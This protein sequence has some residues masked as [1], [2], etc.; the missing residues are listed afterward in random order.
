[1]RHFCYRSNKTDLEKQA[2]VKRS[3]MLT[4]RT[5]NSILYFTNT[6]LATKR[7]NVIWESNILVFCTALL[8]GKHFVKIRSLSSYAPY[9]QKPQ[10]MP[11]NQ[12]EKSCTNPEAETPDFRLSFCKSCRHSLKLMKLYKYNWDKDSFIIP[13]HSDLVLVVK[14]R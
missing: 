10:K 14:V 3:Q 4:Y 8:R 5:E 9:Q 2:E 1:M 11:Q 7:V 6:G 12:N 13:L